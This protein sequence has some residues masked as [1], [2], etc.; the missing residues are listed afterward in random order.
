MTP[1]NMVG[2][3]LKQVISTLHKS[4]TV[5]GEINSLLRERLK[6]RTNLELEEVCQLLC[7]ILEQFRRLYVCIDAL[8]ECNE[9]IA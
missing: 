4:S 7:Q 8:D 2:A 5:P 9:N 1:A 3:I 6:D